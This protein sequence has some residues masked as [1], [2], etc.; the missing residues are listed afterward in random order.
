MLKVSIVS[1]VLM[2]WNLAYR[3]A[4]P[5]SEIYQ[6]PCERRPVLDYVAGLLLVEVLQR[7]I[8]GAAEDSAPD[9]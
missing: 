2:F 8:V 5:S 1:R 9:P 7:L 6:D 3:M 4:S